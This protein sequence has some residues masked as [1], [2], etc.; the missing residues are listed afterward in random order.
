MIA[1]VASTVER[2]H[3]MRRALLA[4]LVA[5][6]ASQTRADEGEH[7]IPP[8]LEC[9]SQEV[10]GWYFKPTTPLPTRYNLIRVAPDDLERVCGPSPYMGYAVQA[11]AIIYH[12]KDSAIGVVYHMNPLSEI[13]LQHELCHLRGWKHD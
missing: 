5:C 2:P 3:L 4:L 7:E 6:S 11:C 13:T 10:G 8:A 12:N 1:F 9:P